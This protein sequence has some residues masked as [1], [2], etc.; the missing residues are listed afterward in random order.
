MQ[1]NW[2]K[3]RMKDGQLQA[4]WE[5]QTSPDRTSTSYA[6]VD[7]DITGWSRDR[8]VGFLQGYIG[9]DFDASVVTINE[10]K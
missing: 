8:V 5:T 6:K 10:D 3:A 1:I 4:T 9:A 7:R 2:V